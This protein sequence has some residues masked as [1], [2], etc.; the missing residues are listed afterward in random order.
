MSHMIARAAGV[1]YAH[2]N[3]FFFFFFFFL[4]PQVFFA[5]YVVCI[6]GGLRCAVAIN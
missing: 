6:E 4:A 5:S 3:V 1:D 2:V